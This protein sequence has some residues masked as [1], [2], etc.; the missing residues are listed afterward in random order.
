MSNPEN[1]LEFIVF[2]SILWNLLYEAL[3]LVSCNSKLTITN[4]QTLLQKKNDNNIRFEILC[5]LRN[6]I[7]LKIVAEK[8]V[9]ICIW[10]FML[11]YVFPKSLKL[12][13]VA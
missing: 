2:C 1:S 6:K 3:R 11:S 5:Y 10:F 8:I 7:P 9:Y 12:P 13:I 4:Y